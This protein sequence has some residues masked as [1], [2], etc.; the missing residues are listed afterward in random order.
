MQAVNTHHHKS[1]TINNQEPTNSKKNRADF[2]A[3][4]IEV[5]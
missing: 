1:I 5:Y 3:R 4:A 2:S